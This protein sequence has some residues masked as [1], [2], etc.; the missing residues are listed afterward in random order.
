M[1]AISNTIARLASSADFFV[2]TRDHDA[3]GSSYRDVT[4]GAWTTG[5]SAS[6]RYAR[7]LTPGLLRRCVVE[8]ACD[9]IWLNSFFSTAS[10]GILALRR[11]GFIHSPILLAPRG[12]FAPAALAQKRRRKAI[13]MHLLRWIGGP[14]SIHWLASSEV[15]HQEIVRAVGAQSITAVTESVAAVP[16][17]DDAWPAKS[18][19]RLNA[20]FASRIVPTKNL[21]FLLD[22][23]ATCK[24]EIHL[25]VIGPPE[26]RDYWARCQAQIAQ[27]PPRVTVA[28]AGEVRHHDLQQRLTAYDLL[29]LPTR[30]ENFGHIVVEAWASGCPVLVSDRTRWRDLTASGVG[31][32]VPLD[33][34]A[35]AAVIDTCVEMGAESHRTMRRTAREYARRVWREG[36]SGDRS[37]LALMDVRPQT[38]VAS[39]TE[40]CT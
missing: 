37:L 7:R 39:E 30:G 23:L 20:V 17:G 14:R 25:D 22:V 33:R 34:E 35:W 3:D 8:S 15:E 10:L 16:D 38:I 21:S 26:D 29:I 9:V 19:R 5:S 1:R 4:P 32:D 18:S 13:A 27:L 6:V 11:M 31:W 12:E 36:V 2:V 28:Y 40:P 24:G